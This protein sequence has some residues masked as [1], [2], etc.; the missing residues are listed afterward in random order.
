MPPAPLGGMKSHD[1][2]MRRNDPNV[3][4][5]LD[6]LNRLVK[7]EHDM[8]AA[9]ES[10][11]GHSTGLQYAGVITR[12]INC[13]DLHVRMLSEELTRLGQSTPDRGDASKVIMKGDV[14]LSRLNG[15]T[16]LL[17][18]LMRNKERSIDGYQKALNIVQAPAEARRVVEHCLDDER[19]HLGMLDRLLAS[20]PRPGVAA[21][22]GSR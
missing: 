5:M 19:R 10:A 14:V 1:W 17:E 8:L 20:T 7:R 4:S 12:M 2:H 6:A 13:S 9:L 18:A 16:A 22:E 21:T 11:R 3:T 15:S